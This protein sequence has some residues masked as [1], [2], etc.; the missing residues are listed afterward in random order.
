MKTDKKILTLFVILC[1]SV[2]ASA[3]TTL[4]KLF[5]EQVGINYGSEVSPGLWIGGT[6]FTSRYFYSSESALASNNPFTPY[7]GYTPIRIFE[8]IIETRFR[9]VNGIPGTMIVDEIDGSSGLRPFFSSIDTE[10]LVNLTD[11]VYDGSYHIGFNGYTVPTAS[12][13]FNQ[14]EQRFY[15][16]D[17]RQYQVVPEPSSL[18]LLALGGVVVALGRRKRA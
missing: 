14:S 10:V 4:I 17:G 18:S 8:Q 2:P 3:S 13:T 1:L 12:G 15:L 5:T 16:S 9:D 7:G 6:V 11:W